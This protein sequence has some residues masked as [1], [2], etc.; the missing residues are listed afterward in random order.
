MLNI[1][2]K[3]KKNSNFVGAYVRSLKL[4]ALKEWAFKAAKILKK[5]IYKKK[6]MEKVTM[7]KKH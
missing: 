5:L 3:S 1:C 7:Q 4:N 6:L 2:L